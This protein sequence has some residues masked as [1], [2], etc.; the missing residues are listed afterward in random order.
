LILSCALLVQAQSGRRQ[1][2]VEPAAPIPTPTPEPTP[3]PKEDKKESEFVLFVGMDRGGAF[4]RYQYSFYDAALMG[5]ADEL[6]KNASARVEFATKELTRSEAI[7]KAKSDSKVYVVY[8]QLRNP[9]SGSATAAETGDQIELEYTVFAPVTAKTATSGTSF[10]NAR[11][12]GPVIMSPTGNG[13]TN[14][15]YRHELLK[16][17]GEDA[18]HR[19]LKALHLNDPKAH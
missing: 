11:R 19:I 9:M 10:Q 8:L 6:R 12:A 14:V 2:R 17:A 5:C 4:N 13:S 7:S 1:Q 3:T 15:M 18:A 16:R